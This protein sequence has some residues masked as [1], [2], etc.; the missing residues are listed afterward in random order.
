MKKPTPVERAAA[1]IR[2]GRLVVFPTET[3]YGLG[4]DALNEAAVRSIFAAK[5]RPADNPLI[6]HVADRSAVSR[7]AD[8]VPPAAERLLD[9]FS[10]GPLTLV[11]RARVDVPRTVTAGLSTVAVRIPRHPVARALLEA[12]ERP[13]AAPSANR[14][15]GPSPTTVEMARRALGE[16]VTCYLDGGSCEV[17]VEST[18]VHVM[19]GAVTILRPG[20]VTAE[21]IRR[22]LPGAEIATPGGTTALPV[23]GTAPSPGMRH[24]HYRPR[25]AVVLAESPDRVIPAG[26]ERPIALIGLDEDVAVAASRNPGVRDVVVRGAADLDAFARSLYRWFVELDD[27][28]VATILAFMPP[29]SGVGVAVRDRLERASGGRRIS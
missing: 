14:S 1:A 22:V 19:N 17:G 18:V 8:S 3:V 7:V 10:P 26:L 16:A 11:L 24:V 4:A 13:I 12:S 15:G 2:D 6:I 28:G 21:A 29:E 25:A 23:R 27:L 20:A 5:G 9:A